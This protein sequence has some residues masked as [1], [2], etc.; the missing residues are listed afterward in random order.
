MGQA[1]RTLPPQTLWPTIVSPGAHVSAM[2]GSLSP[3]FTSVTLAHSQRG[4]R[5]HLCEG[6]HESANPFIV[7]N[8]RGE[9]RCSPRVDSGYYP[10][11]LRAIG[12]TT[13]PA[14][15]CTGLH[16]LILV[17]RLC[18]RQ[19]F[20]CL[21]NRRLLRRIVQRAG[22]DLNYVKEKAFLPFF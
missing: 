13:P 22:Y 18:K 9:Q 10:A 2:T 19:R 3:L 1:T 17:L 16:H 15:P 8:H 11:D 14:L 20:V 5:T 7:H 6:I 12:M 21:K 4:P